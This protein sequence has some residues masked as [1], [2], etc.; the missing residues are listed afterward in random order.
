MAAC[1]IAEHVKENNETAAFVI[2]A[3]NAK[4][5]R[6]MKEK[7]PTLT[8]K[9]ANMVLLGVK[10]PNVQQRPLCLAELLS[11]LGYGPGTLSLEL[12]GVSGQ[13]LAWV[14]TPPLGVAAAFLLAACFKP[15][16]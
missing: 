2:D 5:L 10:G 13:A 6:V 4:N 14:S 7:L 12:L 1:I 3:S 16:C 8:A 9:S 11:I 15:Q